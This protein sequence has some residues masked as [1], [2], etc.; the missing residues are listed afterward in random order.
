MTQSFLKILS[1]LL[2][3]LIFSAIGPSESASAQA[4]AVLIKSINI[5]S[6]GTAPRMRMGDLNGDGRLDILM[7]QAT[8]ETPSEV[9]MLTAFDGYTGQQL[10]QVGTDNGLNGTD[11]DEPAQIYDIDND[12][13]NEV[14]AVMNTKILFLNGATGATKKSMNMP[15]GYE[16]LHDCISFANFTGAPFAHPQDIILKDRYSKVVA[17]NING[18]VLWTYSGITGHYPWPVDING[19]GI[20]EYFVGYNCLSSNGQPRYTAP[21]NVDHP[22]CI[23]IGDVD[24]NPSNGLEVVYGLAVNPSTQCVSINTGKVIWTNSDRRETQQ[25]ML[26]DF[27]P[28]LPGLEVYGM[29]RVNRTNEDALFLINSSGT[30]IWEETPDT[31]GWLTAI[32][33]IHNW[34]GTNTPHCLAFK[35]GGGILPEIRG[36]MGTIVGRVPMDGNACIGD[37]GGDSK[38]EIVMYSGTTANIYAISQFDYSQPAPQPGHPLPQPKEYYNYSR[39]GSGQAIPVPAEG[40]PQPPQPTAIAQPTPANCPYALGDVNRSGTI[41]IVDAL[42][43]AQSYVG[44]IVDIQQCSADVNKDGIVD[45]IDALKIAQCYVGL[46][47]CSF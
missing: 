20:D 47:S 39:Y 44:I 7:V 11:R 37:F 43:V 16:T 4:Q 9:Q 30:Q 21:I 36:A 1:G 10:W 24:N 38:Q 2:L 35:R 18:A 15:A 34:D 12:G 22:D 40:T 25:I 33:L 14:V 29:D 27:Q 8:S 5:A 31:S 46:I 19:D 13:A 6:G 17:I 3:L 42:L 41:D 26:A 23:W 28:D 32:K 45:I